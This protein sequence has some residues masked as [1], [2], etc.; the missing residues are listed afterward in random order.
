M[1]E[2]KKENFLVRTFRIAAQGKGT[3]IVSCSSYA[4]GMLAGILPYLSVYF[5]ARKLLIPQEGADISSEIMLWIIITGVSI[6]LNMLLT[7]LGSY[8]CHRVAFRLL[9]NFRVKVMKHIGKLS[10]GFFGV[11][12]TGGVQKTM[13]ENIEKIEG[14]VAHMLPDIIGSLLVLIALFAGL[15][16]LSGWLALTV[17]LSVVAAIT[18]QMLVFGGKKLRQLWVD[19][20]AASQNVTGAFS[21]Y[22]K[23]MAE[24]KLFGLTGSVTRGLEE[25]IDNYRKWELRQYKRSALPMSAYK[26]IVLSL[27]TFVLPVGIILM[28]NNPGGE[29]MIAVLMALIIT[30]AIYDPLMTCI[31]YGSQMGMLAVGLDAIDEI[32]D[33]EPIPSPA[34]PAKPE[35]WDVCFDDVSFSYQDASDPLRKMALTH[36]NFTAAQGSMTALVGQSGGGK[37]TIGQLLSRFWDIDSG[38]ITIGGIDIQQIDSDDLMD[39][40]ATVFQ[41]TYLFA[42]SVKGNITMNREYS[43]SEI[44]SAAKA[45]QCHDFITKLPDGYDTRVGTGG[46]RLS[47]GETQ[48]LSIA[49]AILKDSPIVVLDEALAYSDAENE[50]LIQQAIHNLV[51]NKT[52]IIIAH[53]LQSIQAADQILVLKDGEIFERGTHNELMTEPTE[54]RTLWNMQHQADSWTILAQNEASAGEERI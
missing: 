49:R 6:V 36:I 48:R 26:T 31:N 37:S 47:G 51:K 18:L 19:V 14:F 34:N 50:N 33:I 38:A 28:V 53:R 8:G 35:K 13:D 29:T 30:P 10:M 44:E 5:I 42:D 1:R 9:Y 40:V 41:D 7:F 22:V 17:F 27:L 16:Q 54:Y 3:L 21:E 45:A 32:L 43:Q 4:I 23:G 39:Y 52:V 25:N 15:I 12:T 20:A 46:A 11:N 24:V 2:K